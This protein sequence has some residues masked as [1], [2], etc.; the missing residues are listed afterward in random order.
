MYEDAWEE[1]EKLEPEERA[2][3]EVLTE[4]VQILMEMERWDSALAIIGGMLN[5]G[6]SD[7]DLLLAG[8]K[9]ARK[10]GE[11][12]KA[13]ALYLRCIEPLGETAMVHYWLAACEAQLG[14]LKA[15]QRHLAE[16][17]K[18][19]ADMRPQ[20]LK[21]SLLAP[22]WDSMATEWPRQI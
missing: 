3:P 6:A 13:K 17:F 2:H 11:F 5:A 10:A 16:C 15:A 1:L 7:P 21:E 12:A 19:D 4:R 9:A 8:A 18:R 14:E 20:A 22:L